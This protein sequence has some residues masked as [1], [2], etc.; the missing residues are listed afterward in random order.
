[1]SSLPNGAPRLIALSSRYQVVGIAHTAFNLKYDSWPAYSVMDEL[2]EYVLPDFRHA[3]PVR[4]EWLGRPRVV[5][6][7][8]NDNRLRRAASWSGAS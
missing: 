8:D 4:C 2:T 6:T 3:E 5:P 1:M 7:A